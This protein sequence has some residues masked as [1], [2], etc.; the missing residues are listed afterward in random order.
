[1]RFR[2]YL[3]TL[4]NLSSSH[5][6][7]LP[8]FNKTS[9]LYDF[10]PFEAV[11]HELSELCVKDEKQWA[12]RAPWRFLS[13]F[14]ILTFYYRLYNLGVGKSMY[15]VKTFISFLQCKTVKKPFGCN[16][17]LN[18]CC[19][20]SHLQDHVTH[21]RRKI[22]VTSRTSKNMWILSLSWIFFADVKRCLHVFLKE[23]WCY[24]DDCVCESGVQ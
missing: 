4:L 6:L 7:I 22:P 23:I 17:K 12:Q 14:K 10:S 9:T 11:G 3:H 21:S 1:M 13:L 5:K 2:N 20:C 24:F 8:A 18:L 19:F 16:I 15:S